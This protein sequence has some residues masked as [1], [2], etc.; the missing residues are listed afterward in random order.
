MPQPSVPDHVPPSL[1]VDL[2]FYD[3]VR[4]DEEAQLAWKRFLG[5]GP[6]VWSPRNG[7][8]WV[9]TRGD[10]IK[11]LYRDTTNLSGRDGTAIPLHGGPRL[12]PTDT[13]PP[14]L[15]EYRRAVM[16]FFAP[17]AIDAVAPDIRKRA[18][19][20]ID[21]IQ[22][23]GEC[24]FVADFAHQLPILV[25][26]SIFGL[27]A[28]DRLLL[29]EMTANFTRTSDEA[30]KAKAMAGV[31]A[32]LEEKIAERRARPTG[33]VISR[34]IKA[35]FNDRPFTPEEVLNSCVTLL[36]AGLDT[37]AALLGFVAGYLARE[38]EQRA[39][40]RARG[41]DLAPVIEELLRRFA[42]A[43]LGRTVARDFAL[44]GVTLK[45]G[46]RILLSTIL[47][48]LDEERFPDPLRVNFARGRIAHLTFGSGA[49]ACLGAY[50]AR[51]EMAIF[52]E[53]WLTRIPEFEIVPGAHPTASSGGIDALNS[54]PLR[55]NG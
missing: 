46:D 54:L 30:A 33:D 11:A 6:L 16:P 25:F 1:V 9:A 47:H 2:D 15:E 18:I 22:A 10:D 39:A 4:G 37:V 32:Y 43:N 12:L 17:G 48:N 5:H 19:D 31:F 53:E 50:L 27:P 35:K 40:I 3:L 13:D 36:M 29:L 20:M 42:V 41:K 34:L 28:E 49:H 26:L 44:H 7:G 45:A 38:P 24:E 8:H 52:L 23:R 51:T 14:E 21:A 55:W